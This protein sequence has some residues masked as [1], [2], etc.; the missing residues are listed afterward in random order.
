MIERGQ[1]LETIPTT[2]VPGLL[3]PLFGIGAKDVGASEV[4]FHIRVLIRAMS[5]SLP[6]GT[7]GL[8]TAEFLGRIGTVL[9]FVH[10]SCFDYIDA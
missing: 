10:L 8:V 4:D 9:T 3:G 5:V 2:K 1:W 7:H 6:E